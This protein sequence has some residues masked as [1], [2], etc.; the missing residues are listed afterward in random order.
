MLVSGSYDGMI[1]VWDMQK[2]AL[3]FNLSGCE[4]RVLKIAIDERRIIASGQDGRILI[5]DFAFE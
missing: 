2:R 1:K 4:C 5:F 3:S